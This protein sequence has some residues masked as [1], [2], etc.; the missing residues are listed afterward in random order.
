M[1]STILLGG[2][3]GVGKSTLLTRNESRAITIDAEAVQA[4]AVKIVKGR[5][6]DKPYS[7][8]VWD[9]DLRRSALQLLKQALL[10][11]YPV[12]HDNGKPLL[13]A[14]AI[15][16]NNWFSAPFL[17]VLAETFPQ[18]TKKVKRYVLHLDEQTI[19]D[20]ITDRCT[21]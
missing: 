14:G 8:D 6:F 17:E 9:C 1:T 21:K 2:M 12:L 3:R 20:Q 4:E 13:V 5:N 19:S 7:W 10:V 16:V 15:L 11:K 18:Q